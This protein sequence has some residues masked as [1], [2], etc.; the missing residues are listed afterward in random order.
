MKI[1]N[2]EERLTKEEARAAVA[3]MVDRWGKNQ[4]ITTDG[5]SYRREGVP[6]EGGG[7]IA[8]SYVRAEMR[9]GVR[10]YKEIPYAS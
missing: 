10:Y 9:K 4:S 5:L 1:I 2:G 8:I 7:T 3:R 6:G